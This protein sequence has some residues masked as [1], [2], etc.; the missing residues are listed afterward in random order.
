MRVF[1]PGLRPFPTSFWL[2]LCI[3]LFFA[4][5][6]VILKYLYPNAVLLEKAYTLIYTKLEGTGSICS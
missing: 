5:E 3:H 2:A 6:T 4:M 1:F